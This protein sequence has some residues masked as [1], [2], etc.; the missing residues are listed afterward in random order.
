[1][2]RRR[3]A[4]LETT[5]VVCMSFVRSSLLARGSSAMLAKRNFSFIFLS[6]DFSRD[7]ILK[8]EASVR[9]RFLSERSVLFFFR[10]EGDDF[11]LSTLF[12]LCCFSFG[13]AKVGASRPSCLV[14][15]L[16]YS[17]IALSSL[18]CSN[19]EPSLVTSFCNVF[20]SNSPSLRCY[21]C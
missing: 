13:L 21:S 5:F 12:K 19:V 15:W 4:I 20:S 17:I 11:C 10:S 14:C 2:R 6:L 8:S 9:F 7:F 16:R 1:M 3:I 18:Y